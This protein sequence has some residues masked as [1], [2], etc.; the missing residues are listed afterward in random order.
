MYAFILLYLITLICH[1]SWWLLSTFCLRLENEDLLL[2]W[3]FEWYIFKCFSK[4]KGFQ[5]STCLKFADVW[6]LSDTHN[7]YYWQILT[8]K[9]Q[10]SKESIS[11]IGRLLCNIFC[12]GASPVFSEYCRN[13]ERQKNCYSQRLSVKGELPENFVVVFRACSSFITNVLIMTLFLG[14]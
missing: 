6:V 10:R 5:N 11:C 9:I 14:I 13:S 8:R 4:L 7:G 3:G 1:P 12:L 2:S